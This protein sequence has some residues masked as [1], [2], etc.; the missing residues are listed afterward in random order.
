MKIFDEIEIIRGEI[1]ILF[2]TNKNE[3][4][5]S[6][7]ENLEKIYEKMKKYEN[8]MTSLFNESFDTESVEAMS[9][10]YIF[11]ETDLILNTFLLTS[12]HQQIQNN[13]LINKKNKL[14]KNIQK[15]LEVLLYII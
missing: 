10:R 1:K 8:E 4:K 11:N 9:H 6:D 2:W 14:Q 7:F 13:I 3:K 15:I 12:V 5:I